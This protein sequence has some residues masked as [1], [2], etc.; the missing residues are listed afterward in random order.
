ME[1]ATIPIAQMRK[2]RHRKGKQVALHH[3]AREWQGQLVDSGTIWES[4]NGTH[5]VVPSAFAALPACTCLDQGS[6]RYRQQGAAESLGLL[7]L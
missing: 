3:L 6:S 2:P 5:P 4:R 1:R 7:R